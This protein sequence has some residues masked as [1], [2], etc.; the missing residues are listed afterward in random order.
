MLG[1]LVT[2]GVLLL[3][4]ALAFAAPDFGSDVRP[5]FATHCFKCH[6]AEKQKSGY[7]LDVKSIALNGGEGSAPNILP[8]KGATSPLVKY[9]KGEVED[10]KMPP[11]GDP[12]A[13]TEIAP[14][15]AEIDAGPVWPDSASVAL[16]DPL[17][18]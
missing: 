15:R 4:P 6:G 11:K 1:R 9:L 3:A 5:I 7:R 16:A 2:V 14:I 8:G 12:L 17:D 10:M 13:P 18:R